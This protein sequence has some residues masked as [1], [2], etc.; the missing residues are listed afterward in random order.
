MIVGITGGIGSG[1]ST[2]A[3]IFKQLGIAV[4]D[5][6]SRAKQL[7]QENEALK[8][9]LQKVLQKTIINADGSLNR[10]LI[11]SLIFN[12]TTLLQKVNALVHPAVAEDFTEWYKRQSS[13]YVLKESALIF[14]TNTQHLCAAVILV[15]APLEVRVKRVMKRNGLSKEAVL[16][17]MNNQW[18]QEKKETLANFSIENG[19]E[20]SLIK[21]V[22]KL[23]Q[24]LLK[25]GG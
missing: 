21:Q 4:Y 14:E 3:T 13:P 2:V 6:D 10:A 20:V 18:P 8:N 16:E 24:E 25:L 11:A 7:M 1:K 5:T 17:R 15:K 22:V 12:N 23:H 19:G 9:S